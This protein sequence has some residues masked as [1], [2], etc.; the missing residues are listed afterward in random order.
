MSFSKEIFTV[1]ELGALFNIDPQTL[2]YY[3]SLGLFSPQS[4]SEK[5]RI[6]YYPF[7]QAYQ[8]AAIRFLRQMDCPIKQVEKYIQS[9]DATHSLAMLKEQSEVLQKRWEDMRRMQLGL[10]LKINFIEKELEKITNLNDVEIRSYPERKYIPI[11]VED[12]LYQNDLFYLA[13]TIVFNI[14]NKKWFAV[15]LQQGLLDIY[16]FKEEEKQQIKTI[17]A[18]RF[19]CGYHLGPYTTI[20][21]TERHIRA[22]AT[23]LKLSD[24]CIFTNIIDMFVQNDSQQF[25]S[26]VEIAILD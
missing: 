10:D 17:P 14:Q 5:S 22:G 23:H 1:G 19:L 15:Y 4:R 24:E 20:G 7:E 6:R 3:D 18:G 9:E 25:V 26:G 2:R 12:L 13:P 8:L 16:P 11:G 21:E